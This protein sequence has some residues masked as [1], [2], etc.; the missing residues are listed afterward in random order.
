MPPEPTD[1]VASTSLRSS[2]QKARSVGGAAATLLMPVRRTSTPARSSRHLAASASVA[3]AAA[4]QSRSRR[5]ITTR[6]SGCSATSRRLGRERKGR[7]SNEALEYRVIARILSR[8]AKA[9]SSNAADERKFFSWADLGEST[10]LWH[11]RPTTPCGKCWRPVHEPRRI[12]VAA[13]CEPALL[14]S[15]R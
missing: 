15:G 3:P 10:S 4:C 7:S 5:A 12:E 9:K 11:S 8:A 1:A 14:Q 2:S 6:S 13:N